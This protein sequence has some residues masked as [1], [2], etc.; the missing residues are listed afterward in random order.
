MVYDNGYDKRGL[1]SVLPLEENKDY[2]LF[3]DTYIQR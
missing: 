3:P 1:M 2:I